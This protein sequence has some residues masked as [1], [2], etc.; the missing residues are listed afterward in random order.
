MAVAEH[1]GGYDKFSADITDALR[2]RRKV[3][4]F[5]ATAPD[6]ADGTPRRISGPG[7]AGLY[8]SAA[9]IASRGIAAPANLLTMRPLFRC[10]AFA[11]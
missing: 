10:A 3:A 7:A 8:R 9:R 2:L 1:E 11:C 5:A 6:V 4:A